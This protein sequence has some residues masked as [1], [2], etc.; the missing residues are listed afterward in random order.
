MI[1]LIYIVYLF[2]FII[3]I[4]LI[5]LITTFF[6]FN[7]LNLRIIFL[8]FSLNY[9]SNGLI[10]IILIFQELRRFYVKCSLH[11]SCILSFSF[12]Q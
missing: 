9:Y 12:K 7:I 10:I 8:S 5:Y 3:L 4:N 6:N 2:D 11:S 1:E